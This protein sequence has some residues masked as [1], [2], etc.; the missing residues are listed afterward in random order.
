MGG[1]AAS[2]HLVCRVAVPQHQGRKGCNKVTYYGELLL[3]SRASLKAP[4]WGSGASRAVG[5][6]STLGKCRISILLFTV[7]MHISI[8]LCFLLSCSLF[9]LVG[10]PI[11]AFEANQIHTRSFWSGSLKPT[12]LVLTPS[13]SKDKNTWA[14]RRERRRRGL[15]SEP[16]KRSSGIRC[17]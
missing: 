17:L 7:R 9:S 6:P 1:F 5:R 14:L 8:L 11:L 10:E 4:H 16:S 12:L 13:S 2:V 3:A 15:L